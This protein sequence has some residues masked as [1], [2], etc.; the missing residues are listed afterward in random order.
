MLDKSAGIVHSAT[1]AVLKI[2]EE[3][4][5]AKVAVD[6]PPGNHCLIIINGIIFKS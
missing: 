6:P 5:F 2:M 4:S 1:Y 3:L